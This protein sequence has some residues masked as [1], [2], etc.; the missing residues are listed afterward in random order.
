MDSKGGFPYSS[1]TIPF[2]FSDWK[3][4]A[5]TS[6]YLLNKLEISKKSEAL[7]FFSTVNEK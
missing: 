5:S 3:S 4:V 6:W 1:K 2:Q 7:P